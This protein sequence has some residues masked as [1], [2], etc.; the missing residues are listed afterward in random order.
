MEE[1][2][3]FYLQKFPEL[4]WAEVRGPTGA[5]VCTLQGIRWVPKSYS[6]WL[7]PTEM[8]IDLSKLRSR[9]LKCLVDLATKDVSVGDLQWEHGG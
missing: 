3:R 1:V 6:K 5:V 4:S 7:M 2:F 9:S 8:P